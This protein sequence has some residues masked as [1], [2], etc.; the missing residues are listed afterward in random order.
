M[1]SQV[2]NF[3]ALLF[4]AA[5]VPTS[6]SSSQTLE[7]RF[8]GVVSGFSIVMSVIATHV[9]SPAARCCRPRAAPPPPASARASPGS[10]CRRE[11]A[12]DGHA[13]IVECSVLSCLVLR[14]VMSLSG[15]RRSYMNMVPLLGRHYD[16]CA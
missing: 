6:C 15:S 12:Q 5:Q 11:G 14:I 8:D 2:W 3:Y 16:M 10:A 4:E 13:A 9:I 1:L 7:P